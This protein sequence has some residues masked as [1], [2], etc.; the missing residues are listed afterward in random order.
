MLIAAHALSLEIV[1]NN[2]L[3]EFQRVPELLVENWLN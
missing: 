1:G 3:K 2:N